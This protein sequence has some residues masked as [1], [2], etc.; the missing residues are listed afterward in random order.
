MEK[1]SE[2]IYASKNLNIWLVVLF[3]NNKRNRSKMRKRLND[4]LK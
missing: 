4:Y 1:L 3:I 2:V